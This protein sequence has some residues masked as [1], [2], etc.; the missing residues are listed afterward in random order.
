MDSQGKNPGQMGASAA[1]I[2]LSSSRS[3][4]IRLVQELQSPTC[5]VIA[6]CRFL[7]CNRKPIS[8][9]NLSP[10]SCLACRWVGDTSQLSGGG[11]TKYEGALEARIV[12]LPEAQGKAVAAP[13]T[14]YSSSTQPTPCP[15]TGAG[16]AGGTL[17]APA[18]GACSRR[19]RASNASPPAP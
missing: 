5:L 9:S 8:N 2:G 13:S 12:S 4:D 11:Q 7:R 1:Q 10:L 15:Q 3:Q 19:P 17:R 6:G 16:R 14:G 18:G